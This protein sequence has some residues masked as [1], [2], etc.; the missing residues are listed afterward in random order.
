MVVAVT[1]TLSFPTF[2]TAITVHV[3]P[4]LVDIFIHITLWTLN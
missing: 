2:K 3:L 4:W 1:Q